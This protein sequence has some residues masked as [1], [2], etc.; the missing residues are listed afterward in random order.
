[1][2]VGLR[3]Y[4]F[5][6]ILMVLFKMNICGA[7]VGQKSEALVAAVLATYFWYTLSY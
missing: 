1:M 3:V 4:K 6:T 5:G 2:V 7:Q